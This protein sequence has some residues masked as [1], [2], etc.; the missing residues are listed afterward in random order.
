MEA[1]LLGVSPVSIDMKI[2]LNV[3]GASRV[4]RDVYVVGRSEAS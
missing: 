2:S 3:I 1:V 4:V